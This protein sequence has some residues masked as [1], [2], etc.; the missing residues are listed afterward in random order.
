M[1]GPLDT[2]YA[3]GST[4]LTEGAL[5]GVRALDGLVVD[6]RKPIVFAHAGSG[7][8]FGGLLLWAAWELFEAIAEND[9]N[10]DDIN[11][12]VQGK[13]EGN[14]VWNPPGDD[15]CDDPLRNFEC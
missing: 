14:G 7:W 8:L 15:P 13:D 5:R 10:F 9:W 12:D 2:I 1:P 11:D 3:E 6:A 4:E